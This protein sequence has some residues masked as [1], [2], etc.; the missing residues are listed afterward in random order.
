MGL[1]ER[2]RKRVRSRD[3]TNKQTKLNSWKND[4][5][6]ELVGCFNSYD[7]NSTLVD[8]L[9]AFIGSDFTFNGYVEGDGVYIIIIK[10]ILTIKL[11]FYA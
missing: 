2:E 1:G 6:P 11:F 5:M 3:D 8:P 4:I 10:M 7:I 9:T